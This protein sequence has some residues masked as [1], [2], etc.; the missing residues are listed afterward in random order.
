MYNDGTI[1]LRCPDDPVASALLTNVSAPV[2]AASAN[3]A[4]HNP[5]SD[6]DEAVESLRGQVDIVLDAGRT[7]YSKPS[8]IVH[9]T[10][11]GF[12]H[13]RDGVLDERTI[14]RLARLNFLLIC[15][16]NTCRSPMAVGI[17][18]KLLAERF[19]CDIKELEQK[20][21]HVESAG[22]GALAGIPASEPGVEVM[23]DRGID[24]SDHRSRPVSLELLHRADYVFT[25]TASHR[26]QLLLDDPTVAD[27]VLTLDTRDIADPIGGDKA[28]YARCADQ[29]E[30]ALRARLEE[31]TF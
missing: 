5:P 24:I 25:M 10:A 7:R 11:D 8:T 13:I 6:A 31:I 26:E 3:P 12:R 9:V 22:T 15:S 4:G 21:I 23:R 27:R 20:D 30:Q 29:I 16:G 18:R 28:T 14:R 1:G 17:L 2:V 19:D